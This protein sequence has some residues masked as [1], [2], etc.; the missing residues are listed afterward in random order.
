MWRAGRGS[1]ANE[2][3]NS[4]NLLGTKKIEAIFGRSLF[5]LG[6]GTKKR[7]ANKKLALHWG[8]KKF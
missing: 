1:E 5:F 2:E 6:L 3:K 4:L 8:P 7:S